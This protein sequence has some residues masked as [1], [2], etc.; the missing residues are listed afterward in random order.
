[1]MTGK[2][3]AMDNDWPGLLLIT[4]FA[5]AMGVVFLG[6]VRTGMVEA[7]AQWRN[8]MRNR[9]CVRC[10]YSLL[11]NVSGICPECRKRFKQ[12]EPRTQ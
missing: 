3:L 7:E 4:L 5:I 6:Y 1:M 9:F 10:G 12:G 2:V 8:E 11:G